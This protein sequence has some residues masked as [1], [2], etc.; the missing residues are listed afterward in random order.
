LRAFFFGDSLVAGSGDPEGLGWVGRLPTVTPAGEAIAIVNFGVPGETSSE[1]LAR[2]RT[3]T[4]AEDPAP[5]EARVVF[6]FGANDTM[7]E[8]GSLWVDPGRSRKNLV[9]ALD[10]AWELRLPVLVV[11]PAPIE[12][13]AQHKRIIALSDAYAEIC[14]GAK[15]PFVAVARQLIRQGDWVREAREGDGAHPRAAGY[16]ALCDLVVPHWERWV[17]SPHRVPPLDPALRPGP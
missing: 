9:A 11:G 8:D 6:S 4:E 1:V 17:S 15:V 10:G 7:E 16:R 2:W 14:A 5:G 13:D 12:D 3:Q